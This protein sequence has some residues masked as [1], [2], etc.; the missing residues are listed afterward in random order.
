[1][2]FIAS[3]SRGGLRTRTSARHSHSIESRLC[4]LRASPYATE[5]TMKQ[6]L[7]GF[8]SDL[9]AT[10]YS[11]GGFSLVS[12]GDCRSVGLVVSKAGEPLG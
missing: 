9:R 12:R 8:E 5:T 6:I 1:M 4:P 2:R 11:R 10:C 7:A 3:S